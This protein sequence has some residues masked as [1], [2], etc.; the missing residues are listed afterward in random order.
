MFEFIELLGFSKRRNALFSEESFK[1][2]QYEL[3][4]N[5]EVGAVISGTGGFRKLRWKISGKGKQ[6]GLRVIY[7]FVPDHETIY[8]ALAYQKNKKDDLS[9]QEKST[10]FDIT[11]LLGE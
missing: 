7:F 1:E 6:G 4:K 3:C 2:L 5:P 8:L 9:E 11:R 10:L